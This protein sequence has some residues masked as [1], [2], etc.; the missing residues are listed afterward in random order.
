MIEVL[1]IIGGLAAFALLLGP[2]V[3]DVV[4]DAAAGW[5]S[6]RTHLIVCRYCGRPNPPAATVWSGRVAYCAGHQPGAYPEEYL[7]DDPEHP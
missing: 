5:E 1:Q 2:L 6:R 4:R 3:R 7:Y